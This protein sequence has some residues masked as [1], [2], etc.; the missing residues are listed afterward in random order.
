MLMLPTEIQFGW[1]R[2]RQMWWAYSY[3][4]RITDVL[5]GLIYV[6]TR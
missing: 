1:D 3:P 4:A 5:E 2:S 6:P